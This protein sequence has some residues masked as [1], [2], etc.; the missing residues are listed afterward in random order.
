MRNALKNH[1]VWSRLAIM[2]GGPLLRFACIAPNR[3]WLNKNLDVLNM[4]SKHGALV[5]VVA[6][7]RSFRP[8]PERN[9]GTKLI[10]S[11]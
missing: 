9:L 6:N 2:V 10:H 5:I 1:M 8:Q 11:H 4:E 7:T 3:N